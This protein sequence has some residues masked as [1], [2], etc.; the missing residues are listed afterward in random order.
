MPTMKHL[1]LSCSITAF[2]LFSLTTKAQRLPLIKAGNANA[3]ITDGAYVHL[4]WQL[5]PNA[6]PDIYYV[7]VPFRQSQVTLKT[8]QDSIRFNTKPGKVYDFI[9]LLNGKDSCFIKI[10]SIQDTLTQ[11]SGNSTHPAPDTL[12]FELNGSRIYLKGILND[13]KTVNIQFDLGAGTTCVNR[14]V[15]EKLGLQFDGNT[16]VT[17]TQGTNETRTSSGNT[18][19]IGT[20]SWKTVR[21]V[22]VGNMQEGED[23]IIGNS[24]FREKIIEIDY[25]KKRMIIHQKLPV[26]SSRFKKQAVWF[27]QNRPKFQAVVVVGGKSYPF[28]FLF[29]TGRDATMALGSDFSRHEQLWQKLDSLTMVNGRKIVR[30][31]AEIAGVV[32]PDI[33]T[34]AH[35]PDKP[36]SRT[37]LFGNQILNHFNVILD[38]REGMLYLKPNGRSKEPYSNYQDFLESIRGR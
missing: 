2:C 18:L 19:T 26:Y 9:T 3:I 36:G 20:I 11:L 37:T 35:P 16:V 14:Q 28:W 32:F 1:L 21:L 12:P 6:K 31:N 13:S 38:N 15:A 22:Q 7:N 34:N 27:E 30:L 10:A 29:D 17:N 4:N 23:L 8:D 24:L 33:V 25:D 5:D